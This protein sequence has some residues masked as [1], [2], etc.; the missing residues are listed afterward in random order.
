MGS[1]F[2]GRIAETR[3]PLRLDRV[4]HTTVTNP[5]LWEKGI[6]AMLGV[7]LLSADQLIGVLHVGRLEE[8]PFSADDAELLQV[9]GERVSGAT[10]AEELA[11]ERSAATVPGTKSPST[12]TAE[13]RRPRIRR[14][15]RAGGEPGRR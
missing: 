12:T 4:D 13:L 5:I 3:E 8:R 6:K 14:S 2:A 10:R 11:L 15:I 7:P 1:G 9:V